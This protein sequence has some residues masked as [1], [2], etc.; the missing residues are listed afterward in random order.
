MPGTVAPK[1]DEYSGTAILRTLMKSRSTLS[2]IALEI[3]IGF[4]GVYAAFAL[5]AY[6][7]RRD[8]IDRRHQIKR[9]L[10]RLAN[11]SRSLRAG[12]DSLLVR[13]ARDTI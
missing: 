4:I 11:M 1:T 7:E 6:K 13:L 2:R 9:A 3:V 5:G 12:G 8:L 10:T